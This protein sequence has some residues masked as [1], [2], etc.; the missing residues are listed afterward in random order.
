M[1]GNLNAFWTI[2]E[3]T[4]SWFRRCF[5]QE[6][7]GCHV[8]GEKNPIKRMF[9]FS[10]EAIELM[11]AGGMS[12]TE[13]IAQ[14]KHVY[15]RESGEISQEV[16]GSLLTLVMVCHAYD[17]DLVTVAEKELARVEGK[18]DEIRVKQTQK[19]TSESIRARDQLFN[20]MREQIHTELEAQHPG[21]STAKLE[22]LVDLAIADAALARLRELI[23]LQS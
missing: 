13:V 2:Q 23:M 21:A 22:A 17:I 11:Q 20:N 5:G 6:H 18:I 4:V 10:E 14:A 1:A 3:R 16:A 7:G 12:L 19:L 9:A 8:K 15:A